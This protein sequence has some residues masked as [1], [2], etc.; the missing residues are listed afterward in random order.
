MLQERENCNGH[1]VGVSVDADWK[2]R[3]LI[4]SSI[5]RRRFLAGLGAQ[6]CC[7]SIAHDALAQVKGDKLMNVTKLGDRV[8][9]LFLSATD[10]R[11][12]MREYCMRGVDDPM[13]EAQVELLISRLRPQFWLKRRKDGGGPGET[14]L[15]GAPDLP[16]G[17][18]W[19]MRPVSPDAEKKAAE[20]E[21][22][23]GWIARFVTREVPFE[24]LGQ[25]DLGEAARQPSHA[26]GLP[27]KGRLLFFW[28]GASG[29]IESGSHVCHVIYDDTPPAQLTRLPIPA[30]FS[31]MEAAWRAPDPNQI[32]HFETMVRELEA[33]GQ[34]DAAAS[35]REVL[36]ATETPDT[37]STKPFVY[38]DRPMRL[39]ALWV[40]PSRNTIE[41]YQDA[42]LT[43]FADGNETQEH[44][45]LLI[46]YDIGPF[47]SDPSNLRT[48]QPWLMI[49]ARRTRLM[50]PPHPEQ[51]DPRYDAVGN[52]QLPPYPW[53][54]AKL[55]QAI[56]LAEAWQLL[57]QIS[58]ADLAQ[59]DTE[60]TVYFMIPKADLAK[61]DF[62]RVV[63][64]YQQT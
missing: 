23:Q 56:P 14:R 64:T 44:Y 26:E 10:A 38:P 25:I 60:G 6:A 4:N 54:A 11:A 59:A 57:L 15:G 9:P 18:P 30:A 31:E 12:V 46:G 5:N 63:A 2:D 1:L 17:T 43:A 28:D 34:K 45:A 42:D 19:P 3:S 62:S 7:V 20:W 21:K 61:R 24:F 47:T 8:E 55:A 39:E 36:R 53:D 48:T 49:E 40:L 35:I 58:I 41:L 37:S 29:L 22:H 13:T 32:A 16:S 52:D 27:T 33:K 51:D 50:G